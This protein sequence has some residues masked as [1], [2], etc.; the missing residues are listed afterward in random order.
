MIK[1]SVS[2]CLV[3]ISLQFYE[4]KERANIFMLIFTLFVDMFILRSVIWLSWNNASLNLQNLPIFKSFA[5]FTIT[6]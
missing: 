1:I 2:I 6:L 4:D 3:S 5:D